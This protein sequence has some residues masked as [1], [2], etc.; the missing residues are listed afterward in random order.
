MTDAGFA[1]A[2]G[3]AIVTLVVGIVV[4][5][6]R[7]GQMTTDTSVRMDAEDWLAEVS[8]AVAEGRH[9][10]QGLQPDHS[11]GNPEETGIEELVDPLNRLTR[12]LAD[13]T[14]DAPTHMDTRVCRNLA[15][16]S[17]A[18]ADSLSEAQEPRTDSLRT[19]QEGS[20]A[21][22]DRQR[23]FEVALGDMADHVDLL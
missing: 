16:S 5:V 2:T 20:Q 13:L 12:H 23:D 18:L 10:L 8:A 15:V 9:L 21:V 19:V 3:A 11:T 4:L 7:A 17:R 22:F 6:I 14:S 1:V